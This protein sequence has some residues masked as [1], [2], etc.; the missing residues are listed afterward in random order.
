MVGTYRDFT[1]R[2]RENTMRG[3]VYRDRRVSLVRA[4]F[5]SE[6]VTLKECKLRLI[7]SE[8]LP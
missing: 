8:I 7:S 5:R 2:E 4:Y 3:Y 1:V 6:N